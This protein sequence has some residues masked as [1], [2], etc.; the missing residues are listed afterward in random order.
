MN[1]TVVEF[2]AASGVR[3]FGQRYRM[4]GCDLSLT[5]L[6]K[7]VFYQQRIQADLAAGI[8]LPDQSVDAVVS[9]YFWEHIPPAIK[10]QILHHC[11]RIL[12]P[13]GKLIF[14]YDVETDNPLIRHFKRIDL[15]LYKKLF[16]DGDGHV[17]YQSPRENIALF[18][19]SDFTVLEHRGME[20]TWLQSS[21]AYTKLA[22]YQSAAR[23]LMRIGTRFGDAP[24]S[25]LYTA[26]IRLVDSLLCPLL[27]EDWARI[28][29]VVCEKR[30]G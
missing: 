3:Y 2:G 22:Q 13:G 21:A 26:L 25:Y 28:D 14:L 12:K 24:L 27:P 18:E 1:A 19:N 17:G 4:V 16:L 11:Y 15:C 10:P 23:P 30:V 7:A 5:S 20:K 9:S 6:Q 8:P 29:M